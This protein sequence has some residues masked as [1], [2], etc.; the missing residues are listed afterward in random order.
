MKAPR[1]RNEAC[2]PGSTDGPLVWAGLW[3]SVEFG[4][5]MGRD[6]TGSICEPAGGVEKGPRKAGSHPIPALCA[7]HPDQCAL[8]LRGLKDS[9]HRT[10]SAH[11]SGTDLLACLCEQTALQA[12]AV[13]EVLETERGVAGGS[14]SQCVRKS[15]FPEAF[16]L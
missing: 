9:I 7:P 14:C 16:E 5:E 13:F 10:S 12:P 11:W 8:A 3:K 1:L 2:L 6:H 4:E 15:R